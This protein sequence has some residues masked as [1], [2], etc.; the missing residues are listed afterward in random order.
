MKKKLRRTPR[1]YD[2]TELTTHRLNDVL[3]QVLANVNSTYSE[4]P[5][6]LLAAWPEVIGPK[7]AGMTQ[8]VS[9]QDGV[10]HVK[11]KNST[12][13]SLLNQHDKPKLLLKLRQQFPKHD[14]RNIHFRIG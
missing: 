6:L 2:G 11:V 14:I 12:L 10:L 1:N 7:L 4:R 5:D 8:A 13:F 3:T 9:F